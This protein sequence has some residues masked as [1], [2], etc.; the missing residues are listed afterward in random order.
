MK[1]TGILL[2]LLLAT[3]TLHAQDTIR[4]INGK[5]ILARIDSVRKYDVGYHYYSGSI[6]RKGAVSK[7]IVANI[8]YADGRRDT[9]F[10]VENNTVSKRS[11]LLQMPADTLY[12]LGLRD[13]KRYYTGYSGSSTGTLLATFP[14]SPL[15]GFI[16]GSACALTPPKEK[17]LGFPNAALQQN[18]SY[19][20][21]Y[22][23]KARRIKNGKIWASFGIGVLANIAGFIVLNQLKANGPH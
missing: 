13:A 22:Y 8:A 21:G 15:L 1:R 4:K 19:H 17:N 16:V 23:K 11:P 20:D 2:L 6:S 18:T 14:G 12:Q 9:F 7:S 3:V 10:L 5:M